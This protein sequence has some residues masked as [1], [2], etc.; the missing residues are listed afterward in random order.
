[1]HAVHNSYNPLIKIFQYYAYRYTRAV[2]KLLRQHKL[3]GTWKRCKLDF[4][5]LDTSSLFH[6]TCKWSIIWLHSANR[7]EHKKNIT[8]GYAEHSNVA[9]ITSAGYNGVNAIVTA[10]LLLNVHTIQSTALHMTLNPLILYIYSVNIRCYC[11]AVSQCNTLT[12]WRAPCR[13]EFNTLNIKLSVITVCL[14]VIF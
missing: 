2:H 10:S 8:W 6:F 13:S 1:M 3:K 12:V 7:R 5:W 9:N 14:T 4:T 11:N